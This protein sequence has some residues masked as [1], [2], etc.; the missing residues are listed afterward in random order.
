[1][2]L[3][4]GMNS[5]QRRVLIIRWGELRI[6]DLNLAYLLA[7]NYNVDL[8]LFTPHYAYRGAAGRQ[9][10]E[11]ARQH[12]RVFE[13]KSG[14]ITRQLVRI[15]GIFERTFKR[16]HPLLT[17]GV[18]FPFGLRALTKANRYWAVI[19]IEQRS[20][21]SAWRG[22][23]GFSKI[24]YYSLEVQTTSD[25]DVSFNFRRMLR[26]ER[27]I[28]PTL[29]GILIQDARRLGVLG[30]NLAEVVPKIVYLPLFSQRPLYARNSNFLR[31]VLGLE[32]RRRIVLYYGA[33][34]AERFINA[35]AVAF[36]DANRSDLT[37]VFHNPQMNSKDA[38]K[39]DEMSCSVRS[40]LKYLQPD[41]LDDMVASADVGIA[42]YDN[43]K[44]NTRFTAYSSEKIV[45]Y[46]RCGV[47]FI[48]FDNE[49]YRDLKQRYDCCA[50]IGNIDELVDAA[51]SLI[52]NRE[53]HSKEA[54]RAYL[55]VFYRTELQL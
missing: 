43:D 6:H 54:R 18:H 15:H 49:S 20:L 2:S 25:D 1:M 40:S 46:L 31:K 17:V 36:R 41:E 29:S 24:F 35:M 8:A 37:L 42:L 16:S 22:V 21:Y 52:R 5:H 10:L 11:E 28:L 4:L 47:P 14:P 32:E 27:E 23:A 9:L 55:E 26:A 51:A 3:Q 13:W 53:H 39:F 38:D 33:F 7:N 19:P 44:L 34:Y 48:G 30:E 45:T 50:L 12:F